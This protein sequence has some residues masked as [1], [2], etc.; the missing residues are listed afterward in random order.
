MVPAPVAGNILGEATTSSGN[1]FNEAMRGHRERSS[2]AGTGRSEWLR[3]L[4][5][6]S[7]SEA[8]AGMAGMEGGSLRSR[9]ATDS[10]HCASSRWMG[11]TK[12]RRGVRR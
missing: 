3:M 7:S 5:I 1:I 10:P 11:G 12:G 8:S 6:R 4:T 2:A 9:S